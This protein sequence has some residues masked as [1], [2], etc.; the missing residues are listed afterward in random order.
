MSEPTN[1]ELLELLGVKVEKKKNSD[2]SPL[3][4]RLIVG[5]EEI[6]RFHE[7]F[8]RLPSNLENADLHN[9]YFVFDWNL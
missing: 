1:K 9:L 7:E 4:E 8:N 6:Q 2:L 3:E 5:F